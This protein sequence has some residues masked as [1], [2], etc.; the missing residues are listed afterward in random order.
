MMSKYYQ[1]EIEEFHVGFE[2]EYEDINEGGASTSFYKTVLGSNEGYIIDQMFCNEHDMEFRVK[3][4]DR[5]DIEDLLKRPQLK[6]NDVEL[7]FQ[8]I[9]EDNSFYDFD[10]DT[11]YKEL[12][13]EIFKPNGDGTHNCYTLFKGIIKNKSE[14]KKLLKQL[15]IKADEQI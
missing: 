4:L 13:V 2:Y 5:K 8:Y 6:G 7:N 14:F 11:E 10:Y 9:A 15:N 3:Y 1:P 12:T